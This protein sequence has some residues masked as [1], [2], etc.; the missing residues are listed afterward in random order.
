MGPILRD[1]NVKK[2][3]QYTTLSFK[4]G[5]KNDTESYKLGLVQYID[6]IDIWKADTCID[7][8]YQISIR[9]KK[10]RPYLFLLPFY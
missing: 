5:Y 8:I 1:I 3:H 7:T 10:F 2:T 9:E 4:V 6:K